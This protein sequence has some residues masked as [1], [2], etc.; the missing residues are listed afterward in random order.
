M[1]WYLPH[2]A[3]I[4]P[5]KPDKVRVVFDCAA[6]FGGTLLNDKVLQGPDITNQL[7]GVLLR[8]REEP[9][10]IMAD[11]QAMFHQVRVSVSDRDV[12]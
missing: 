8:F 9:V 10:A 3:V 12:L 4:N 1:V 6:N 7:I 5:K 2:H 11:V